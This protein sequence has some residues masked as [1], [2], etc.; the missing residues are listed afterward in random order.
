LRRLGAVGD[1]GVTELGRALARFPVHPRLGRLLLEGQ[2]CGQ[3][4]RAALAA[5]LLAERDPFKKSLEQAA[6]R[7]R[8]QPTQ[9]DVLDRVEALEE[10]DQHGR[11]SSEV[12]TLHP[13]AARF[14]LQSRDQ[15]LRSLRQE[16]RRPASGASPALSADDALLRSLLAAFPDRVARRRDPG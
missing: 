10:Y 6:P 4:D 15:L 9:S 1:K 5:A 3:P 11:V 2:R 12:G 7:L 14:V 8:Q 16:G 13:G